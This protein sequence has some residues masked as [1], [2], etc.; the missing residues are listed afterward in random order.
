MRWPPPSDWP[1]AAHS[2]QISCAPHRWHVQTLGDGPEILLLHG[3]G[4]ATHS[5]RGLAP[6]LAHT[7]R[8]IMVDLPGHGFTQ[9]PAMRAGLAAMAA[10]IA[11]LAI[12]ESWSPIAIIGHSAGAALALEL[13]L[14]PNLWHQRPM[15]IGIN[16]A[17]APFDGV[18]GFLF[19]LMARVLAG[20]SILPALFARAA[21][22]EVAKRLIEGTGS[23]LTSDGYRLY[24]RLLRDQ[25]HVTGALQM[26]ANWNLEPLLAALPRIENPVHFITGDGDGAVPPTV[27][28]QAAA[29]MSDTDVICLDGLGHLAHEE[30]PDKVV[31]II[32]QWTQ[33]TSP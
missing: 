11:A 33:S 13:T 23:H 18:A 2:R 8:V 15:V 26:M 28:E 4:G 16:P 3:A 5:W 27:A 30:D 7:H 21:T 24:T 9:S 17:L 19:P 10:D 12:A 20:S 14:R 32:C 31:N 29:R 1:F 25:N 6:L 22:P